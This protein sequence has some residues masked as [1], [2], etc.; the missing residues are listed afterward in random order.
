MGKDEWLCARTFCVAISCEDMMRAALKM[1]ARLRTIRSVA[2]NAVRPTCA[3]LGTSLG[4][5]HGVNG[6]EATELN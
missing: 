3:S 5:N 1:E 2:A 4:T 6:T